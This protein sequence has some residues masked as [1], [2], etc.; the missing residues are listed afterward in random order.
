MRRFRIDAFS[1][2]PT[3]RKREGGCLL[4]VYL[5]A[6]GLTWGEPL[7]Q[8]FPRSAETRWYVCPRGKPGAMW[9]GRTLRGARGFEGDPVA[10]IGA[11]TC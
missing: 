2:V 9:A 6:D 8:H 1:I 10:A 3:G 11:L 5:S 7:L 4:R